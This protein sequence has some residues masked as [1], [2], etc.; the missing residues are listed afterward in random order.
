V[1]AQSVNTGSENEVAT[2]DCSHGGRPQ[3]INYCLYC[4]ERLFTIAPSGAYRLCADTQS[5]A[6][7]DVSEPSV[8]S[9]QT[10]SLEVRQVPRVGRG[11][12]A[13]ASFDV[14][15]EVEVCEV[16]LVPEEQVPHIDQTVMFSYY[17]GWQHGSA[18][19]ALGFGSLYNHSYRPNADYVKDFESGVIRIVALTAIGPGQEVRIDY[20]RGGTHPL[21]FDPID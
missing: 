13:L 4:G 10:Q 1:D 11:V 9:L 14:G 6:S 3:P 2:A 20:S 16:L 18:V 7:L 12:F 21:W 8:T 19:V 5:Q 17:Y 15:E